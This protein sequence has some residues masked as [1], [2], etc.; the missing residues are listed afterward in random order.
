MGK[1]KTR[2]IQTDL[3]TFGH[4]RAW[5]IVQVYLFRHIRAYSWSCVSLV[6]LRWL[7]VWGPGVFRAFWFRAWHIGGLLLLHVRGPGIFAGLVCSGPPCIRGAGMFGAVSG[8]SGGAFCGD[9]WVLWLFSRVMIIFAVWGCRVLLFIGWGSWGSRPGGG[10]S[11]WWV[12]VRWGGLGPW[13][14]HVL[15]GIFGWVALFAGGGSFG[16]W[17]WPS[18]GPWGGGYLNW[19]LSGAVQVMP[20]PSFGLFYY[21]FTYG[22]KLI[23]RFKW[24]DPE[25]QTFAKGWNAWSLK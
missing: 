2:A 4:N 22:D 14:F 19:A 25:R 11:V 20:Q 10:C 3:G 18:R 5:H 16:L 6:C 8:I 23:N 15:I 7:Y 9:G 1:C 21:L 13:V 17:G 12:M 24:E